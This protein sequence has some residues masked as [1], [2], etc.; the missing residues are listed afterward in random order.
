MKPGLI[1]AAAL[2]LALTLAPGGLA[3][4]GSHRAT[5][6]RPDVSPEHQV[7]LVYAIPKSGKDRRRD[8][9][10]TIASSFEI[11]NVW[12]A[13]QTGGLRLRLDRLADGIVDVTFVELSQ[14]NRQIRRA[15]AWARDEIEKEINALG[16]NA[17]NKV[18]L[19]YYE[20]SSTFACGGS[21]WPPK[22]KG[23]TAALYLATFINGVPCYSGLSGAGD[24][25]RYG[26]FS[27]IHE[28]IH[29]LGL[30]AECA[31]HHTRAGHSSDGN[32]D[33]MYA[34]PLPWEP[35]RVD[36]E[37]DDYFGH[38]IAG[39]PDLAKSAFVEPAVAMP[40]L[41]PEWLAGVRCTYLGYGKR[42]CE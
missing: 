8:V 23:N 1:C 25:P 26:E 4:A 34:G 27:A 7:H 42:E 10:G 20:G 14:T 32:K 6:D 9:D 36:S 16:F 5:V 30:V 28:I 24:P 29:T 11:A 3:V 38:G 19:A 22:L 37:R 12:L 2:A 39:C 17:P 41:P 31:P 15:G 21:A 18:Y 40:E 35:S 13:N 33:L